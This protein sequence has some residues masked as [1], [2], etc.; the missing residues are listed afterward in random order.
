MSET[1]VLDFP[2][3][4]APTGDLI[5]LEG[6]GQACTH[7]AGVFISAKDRAVSCSKCGALIDPFDALVG[8]SREQTALRSASKRE[9]AKADKAIKRT[10]SLERLEK[11]A[12]GRAWRSLLKMPAAEIV[13]A[14]SVQTTAQK[15]GSASLDLLRKRVSDAVAELIAAGPK[16][17]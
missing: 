7:R 17:D 6:G 13:L 5:L 10:A 16:A 2:S 14:Y 4:A 11:N 15:Y 8:L 1:K 12:K 9:A 3:P